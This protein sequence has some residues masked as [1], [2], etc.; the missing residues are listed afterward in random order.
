MVS[1]YRNGIIRELFGILALFIGI[2]ATLHLSHS[3]LNKITTVSDLHSPYLP[4][5]VY[6]LMFCVVFVALIMLGRLLEKI[7]KTAQ[8]NIGNRFGGNGR[9]NT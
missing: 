9:W 5:I 1:G 4:L 6:V 8:L 3:V 2:L 7:I